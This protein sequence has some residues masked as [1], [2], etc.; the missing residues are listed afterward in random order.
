MKGEY[1]TKI[2]GKTDGFIRQLSFHTDNGRVLSVPESSTA[3]FE[4]DLGIPER[5]AV[6]AFS[7]ETQV[8]LNKLS[9]VYLQLDNVS[10]EQI[11]PLTRN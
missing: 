3:E 11:S 4:F 8:Y 7:G 6:I 10:A 9:A 5:S 2:T 1:I